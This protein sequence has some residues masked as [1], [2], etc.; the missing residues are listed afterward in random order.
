MSFS[1]ENTDYELLDFAWRRWLVPIRGELKQAAAIKLLPALVSLSPQPEIQLCQVFGKS[2]VKLDT[3][4]IELGAK[5]LSRRIGT[6]VITTLVCSNSVPEAI[7]D[8][9]SKNQ[10]DVVVV[11]ATREGFLTQVINGNIPEAIARGCHCTV[12]LVRSVN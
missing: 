11:G 9:V 3:E 5:I 1:Q 4:A 10:C 7:I 12:I 6:D 2:V 8:L